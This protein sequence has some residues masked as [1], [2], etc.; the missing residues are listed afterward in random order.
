MSALSK[1]D[2]STL[3]WVKAEID[4][5]L[6]QARLALEAY[7]EN[8]ADDSKLRFCAP[9]LH[10]VLGTLQMVEL[11]GAALLARETEALAES[12]LNGKAA[13]EAPVIETLIR[14]I[15]TLPDY[16]AR[17]QFGQPDAP[18]RVLPLL[19]ELRA[20]RGAAPLNQLDLFQ[21][22]LDVRPPQMEL[23]AARLSEADYARTTASLRPA[24][25]AI[26]LNWVRDR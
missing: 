20:M 14:G 4:E 25:Q 17:L 10:Q 9:S 15:L 21:P 18:P 19:N 24:L 12:V 8:T 3:G 5:T 13:P 1:M 26:L 23:G 7:T 2:P 16:L 6:K 11:D 22:D